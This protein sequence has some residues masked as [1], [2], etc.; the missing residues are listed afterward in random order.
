MFCFPNITLFLNFLSLHT[1]F[2]Y[3]E[4]P[5]IFL[6][7]FRVIFLFRTLLSLF[8]LLQRW[9]LNPLLFYCSSYPWLFTDEAVL[10]PFFFFS[11]SFCT[12]LLALW[13]QEICFS[14]CI[15]RNQHRLWHRMSIDIYILN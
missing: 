4:L 11:G 8:H 6:F 1:G 5:F 14:H 9:G 3:S 2:S 10:T 15:L 13:K 7:L 12:W